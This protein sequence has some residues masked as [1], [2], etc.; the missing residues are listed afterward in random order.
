MPASNYPYGFLNGLTVKGVPILNTYSGNVFWVDSVA[1]SDG[2]SGTQNQPFA[3]INGAIAKPSR[4]L[5]VRTSGA[6]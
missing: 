2:N 1:G 6:P 4:P 5:N 3:S